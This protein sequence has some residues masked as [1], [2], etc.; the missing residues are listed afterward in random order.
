M[1]Q[2]GGTDIMIIESLSGKIADEIRRS[3]PDGATSRAEMVYAL[4]FIFN[5]LFAVVIAVLLGALFGHVGETLV[6][7]TAFA[8]LRYFSAGFHLRS[9]DACALISALLFA[10][11]PFVYLSVPAI[12]IVTGISLLIALKWAPNVME[13]TTRDPAS[14]PRMKWIS[15]ILISSNLI[16]QSEIIALAFLVQTILIIPWRG[17]SKHA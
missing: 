15:V 6:A 2:T 3:D 11:I 16:F 4:N 8:T 10:S 9:L 17:V 14:Y 7:F 1:L 5:F 13:E 12:L